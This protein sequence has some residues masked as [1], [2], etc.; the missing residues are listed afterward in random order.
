MYRFLL[1]SLFAALASLAEGEAVG[2]IGDQRWIVTGTYESRDLAIAE[3]RYASSD[4]KAARVFKRTDGR[5]AV[6]LGPA[7]VTSPEKFLKSDVKQWSPLT[8]KPELSRGEE[9]TEQAYIHK[10]ASLAQATLEPSSR[11]IST[12]VGWGEWIIEISTTTG[13]K[14]ESSPVTFTVRDKSRVVVTETFE[15]DYLANGVAN[16]VR[17]DPRSPWPQVLMSHYSGGAHCCT[18]SRV[19]QRGEDGKWQI[20]VVSDGDDGSGYDLEDLDGDGA[21]ELIGKDNRFLYRFSS[22]VDALA[23]PK[24]LRFSAGKTEDVTREP[25]FKPFLRQ[26]LLLNESYAVPADR[27]SPGYLAGWVATKSLLDEGKEAWKQMLKVYDHEYSDCMIVCKVNLSVKDCPASKQS[28][29]NVSFP[30]S[31][32][33]FLSESGYDVDG[34]T[35]TGPTIRRNCFAK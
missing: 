10:S 25:A 18:E 11:D 20:F 22:Y 9:F 6:V 28:E 33:D 35:T 19:A 26:K 4:G 1:A 2:L 8:E 29:Q 15:S 24:I 21:A 23:P 17:L 5:F 12:K 32:S 30:V 3:A 16:V 14:D 34:V 7:T 27:K 31:L 13:K